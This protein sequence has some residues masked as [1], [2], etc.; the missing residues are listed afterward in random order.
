MPTVTEL[1]QASASWGVSDGRTSRNYTRVFRVT[2]DSELEGPIT[3]WQALGIKIGDPYSRGLDSDQYSFVDNIS[4][5]QEDTNGLQW[6]YTVT[7]SKYN[8]AYN[9]ENP[10]KNTPIVSREFSKFSEICDEDV[11]GVP[12]VATNGLPFDPPVERDQSRPLLRVVRNEA[13][14][15]T[16]DPDTGQEFPVYTED[17]AQSFRD[18]LNSDTFAGKDPY[19]WKVEGINATQTYDPYAGWYVQVEYVFAYNPRKWKK[20]LLNAGLHERG[21]DSTGKAIYV[22]IIMGDGVPATQPVPLDNDGKAIPPP[23]TQDTAIWLN[24]DIYDES[25]FSQFG[26]DEAL[27]I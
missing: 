24:F 27:F 4:P 11:N 7:Y 10:L 18:T 9:Q 3:G 25:D 20:R 23:V 26:F 17:W 8:R 1:R 16:T 19:T 6:I 12:I 13:L 14:T 22:P 5:Q 21:T 15:P 2:L